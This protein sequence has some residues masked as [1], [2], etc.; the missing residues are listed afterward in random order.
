MN[1]VEGSNSTHNT[2]GPRVKRKLLVPQWLCSRPSPRSGHGN[3]VT[4]G[5][6]VGGAHG[7]KMVQGEEGRWGDS[8]H[9]GKWKR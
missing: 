4:L 2:W 8:G 5:E 6:E 3:D 9:W 7:A 1:F